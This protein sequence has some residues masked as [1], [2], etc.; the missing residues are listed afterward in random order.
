MESRWTVLLPCGGCLPERV[1]ASHLK[2][3]DLR[4]RQEIDIT[5]YTFHYLCHCFL[6]VWKATC[7]NEIVVVENGTG[8][9]ANESSKKTWVGSWLPST[10]ANFISNLLFLQ[11]SQHVEQFTQGFLTCHEIWLCT[12]NLPGKSSCQRHV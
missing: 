7:I 5:L 6:L 10:S 2:R 1:L 12:L 11:F 8:Q 9:Q 4:F 3:H